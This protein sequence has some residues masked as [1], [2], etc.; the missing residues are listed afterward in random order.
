MGKSNDIKESFSALV[1]DSLRLRYGRVPSAALLAREFNLRA[2]ETNGISQES[3]RRWLRGLSLPEEQRLKVLVNWLD[4]DFNQALKPRSQGAHESNGQSTAQQ[5]L[6]R[7][8]EDVE[9]GP[10]VHQG[11]SDAR[12]ENAFSKEEE[13]LIRR[14]LQLSEAQRN[15][16]LALIKLGIGGSDAES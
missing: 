16:L 1:R 10:H 4:L 3:A 7:L 5:P 2:Y 14:M 15:A 8:G 6:N 11:N 13:E 12:L 9:I